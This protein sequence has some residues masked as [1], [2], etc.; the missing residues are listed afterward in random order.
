MSTERKKLVSAACEDQA[1]GYSSD[2]AM[3]YA[4]GVG[5]ASDPRDIDEL[6]Y[7]HRQPL[8][9][10][11]PTLA[12]M[13]LDAG[14]PSADHGWDGHRAIPVEQKLELFRPLPMN[15]KLLANRRV[16][17]VTEHHDGTAACIVVQSEVRLAAD[18]TALFTLGSTLMAA[19]Q[20]AAAR[21]EVPA[22]LARHRLPKREPD[23]SCDIRTRPDQALLFSLSGDHNPLYTDPET[24]R[25]AGF[26]APLLQGR[27]VLGIACRAI[28][29]TICGYDYTL[30]KGIEARLA[31]PVFPGDVV[32]T[33]MWQDRN[34]VSFRCYV[35]ARAAIAVDGGRCTLAG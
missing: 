18:D 13:L 25:A 1:V 9:K 4:L 20:G 3:L 19:D 30:I 22:L 31:A 24:A 15:G 28:L 7:V 21:P 29:R 17:D 14:F 8:L 34:I 10:T 26:E 23:L 12:T 32:T 27:C 35:R 16:L 33:D 5:F 6:D 11:V 2:D